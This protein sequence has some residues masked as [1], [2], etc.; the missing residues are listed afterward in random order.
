MD[1]YASDVEPGRVAGDGDWLLTLGLVEL[2]EGRGAEGIA[3]MRR[4]REAYREDCVLCGLAELGRAFDRTARPDSAILY[5]ERY[6]GERE[7]YRLTRA[8]QFLFWEV[9]PRLGKLQAERGN[10]ARG[11]QLFQL[12][13][14]ITEGADPQYEATRGR[15]REALEGVGG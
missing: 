1:A 2:A 7:F 4:A 6:L 10:A 11:R 12:F 3:L 9:V 14:D 15:I 5:Y 8:D 13:L